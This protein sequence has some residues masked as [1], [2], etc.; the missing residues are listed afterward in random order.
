MTA[1]VIAASTSVIVAV[2]AF[3]LNQLGLL[4]QERRTVRLNRVNSQLRDLY[5]PLNA[6]VQANERIWEA[7]RADHLPGRVDRKPGDGG[8]V[9]L[10]WRDEVFQPINR[11]MYELIVP[12]ADLLI[13]ETLPDPLRDFCAH[14]VAQEF[15]RAAEREGKFERSLVAHPGEA[16]VSHVRQSFLELKSQQKVLLHSRTWS[17]VSGDRLYFLKPRRT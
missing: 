9:W 2:L 7:L 5:G 13:D 14:V 4:R 6:L 12:H 1:A 3:V 11:R 17:A 16:F 10:Q 15:V 8:A